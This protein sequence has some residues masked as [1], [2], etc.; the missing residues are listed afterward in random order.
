MAFAPKLHQGFAYSALSKG[1]TT[2]KT[3]FFSEGIEEFESEVSLE[4]AT[5]GL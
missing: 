5:S 4:P 2:T 1:D 3:K